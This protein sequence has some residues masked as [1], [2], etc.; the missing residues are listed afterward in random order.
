MKRKKTEKKLNKI[1]KKLLLKNITIG[2]IVKYINKSIL[3][4][5]QKT[6]KNQQVEKRRI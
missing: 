2:N 6:H 5:K 1:N 4:T 3:Y